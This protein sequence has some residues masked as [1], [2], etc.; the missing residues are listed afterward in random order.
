[1]R[2][3]PEILYWL[4]RVWFPPLNREVFVDLGEDDEGLFA[5]QRA[6]YQELERRYPML[7]SDIEQLVQSSP[8]C[9]DTFDRLQLDRINFPDEVTEDV[10]FAL[11]YTSTVTHW[12]YWVS[13]EDWKPAFLTRVKKKDWKRI[14]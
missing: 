9:S 5:R 14:A 11:G 10:A 6:L 12:A 8:R 7:Q 3:A 2:Y 13:I 1:L 4:G